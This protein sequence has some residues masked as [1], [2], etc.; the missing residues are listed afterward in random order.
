[1]FL[2]LCTA[3]VVFGCSFGKTEDQKCFPIG[4]EQ[5]LR[6]PPNAWKLMKQFNGTFYLVYCS[7]ELDLKD[8]FP[9]LNVRKSRLDEGRKSAHYVYKH[10]NTTTTLTGTKEVQTETKDGAYKHRNMFF[11]LYHE[12]DEYIWHYIELLYTDYMCCAVLNYK[13]F[14]KDRLGGYITPILRKRMSRINQG[15]NILHKV[16]CLA[17]GRL[18]KNPIHHLNYTSLIVI[19]FPLHQRYCKHQYQ[20]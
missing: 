6:H 19:L 8:M 10:A 16:K 18:R 2:F 13:V 3:F 7:K 5:H 14:W 15:T 20:E 9:C 17:P 1:M 12:G 4:V 11:V